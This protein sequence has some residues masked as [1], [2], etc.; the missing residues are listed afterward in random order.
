MAVTQVGTPNAPVLTTVVSGANVISPTFSGTQPRTAGDILVFCVTAGNATSVTIPSAPAGWSTA[1]SVGDSGTP[2]S[3]A[4]VYWK[5][6]AGSDA[7]PSVTVTTGANAAGCEGYLIE[8]TGAGAPDV[9]GTHVVGTAGAVTTI[10]TT[11]SG[12]VTATG[13]YAIVVTNKQQS[14]AATL[15]YGVGSG[16]TN[17]ASDAGTSLRSHSF[18]D[19][20]ASPTAGAAAS[21]AATVTSSTATV[22]SVIVVFGLAVTG[23]PA[24]IRGRNHHQP[25]LKRLHTYNKIR[26]QAPPVAAR[27]PVRSGASRRPPPPFLRRAMRG[28]N[29]QLI[30]DQLRNNF[31]GGVNGTTLTAGAGGNT[32]GAS[33]S[34][35]DTISI[36]AGGAIKFSNAWTLDGPMSMVTSIGST[37]TNGVYAQWDNQLGVVN[38][39]SGAA[40]ILMTSVP[41]T[42]DSVIQYASAGTFR[43]GIQLTTARVLLIQNSA[44]GTV[45]SFSTQIPIGTW[46]RIEWSIV[47]SASV[48]QVTLNLFLN[49]EGTTPTESFTS[50]ASQNFGATANQLRFGWTGAHANQPSLYWTNLASQLFG[51]MGPTGTQVFKVP[52]PNSRG[53]RRNA[54]GQLFR[55]PRITQTFTTQS[56]PVN[57]AFT[58]SPTWH[59]VKAAPPMKTRH[60]AARVIPSHTAPPPDVKRK[61]R[62]LPPVRRA[63]VAQWFLPLAYGPNPATAPDPTHRRVRVAVPARRGRSTTVPPAQ[64]VVVLVFAPD[65]TRRRARVVLSKRRSSVQTATPPAQT[66]PISVSKR[67]T[68]RLPMPTRGKQ[69]T[70]VPKQVNPPIILRPDRNSKLRVALGR[71]NRVRRGFI[72]LGAAPFAHP[73]LQL[74]GTATDFIING[75]AAVTIV[76]GASTVL[77]INGTD[78]V[79]SFN[80]TALVVDPNRNGTASVTAINGTVTETSYNATEVAWGMIA[81]NLTLGE[82]DD[83]SVNLAFTTSGGGALD[84]TAATVDVYLKTAAGVLDSDGTT[85]HYSS[86]GGSPA[87][88]ITNPTGGLATVQIPMADI[89]NASLTF[90]KASVTIGGKRNTAMFGTV[91][92]TL[93]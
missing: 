34:Y 84:L 16:F 64:A 93:L 14:V 9:T 45:H 76:N 63:K 67:R 1:V 80:G 86:A 89:V 27:T 81:A 56:T 41:G 83:S 75:T 18:F 48:G 79:T 15:T 91:T 54:V 13:E 35:F 69:R 21:D 73:P 30:V 6:A 57:P 2:N 68:A 72:A 31:N 25:M 12:N 37:G 44:F 92:T 3:M 85:K 71:L 43:M 22:A 36:V 70:P 32:G 60:S 55:R 90:W 20:Q 61:P 47:F 28:T 11:T 46:F 78:S 65:S 52:A 49:P 8:L 82:F 87:I 26:S 4:A 5:V 19:V 23:M 38:A 62:T 33:G 7:A 10:T 24:R 42:T 29:A 39:D 17:V 40:D 50:A 77:T 66:A 74:G 58:P 53:P 88:T 51:A 59:Q